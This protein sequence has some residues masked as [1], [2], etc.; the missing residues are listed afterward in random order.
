MAKTTVKTTILLI[1][2]L[3]WLMFVLIVGGGIYAYFHADNQ[4]LVA[5]LTLF[6]LAIV[7]QVGQWT[8]TKVAELRQKL[9]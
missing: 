2:T 3:D 1:Q 6:G 4:F 7:N 9:D 5:V 8:V